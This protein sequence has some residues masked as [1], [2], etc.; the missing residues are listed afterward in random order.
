VTSVLVTNWIRAGINL[1]A[2]R[3]RAQL[4]ISACRWM[5]RRQQKKPPPQRAGAIKNLKIN[6]GGCR[7]ER[8]GVRP[9][10]Q[11]VKYLTKPKRT[12]GTRKT[13]NRV[14]AFPIDLEVFVRHN[15]AS[16]KPISAASTASSGATFPSSA[17]RQAS[18]VSILRSV[19]SGVDFL[20]STAIWGSRSEFT[21]IAPDRV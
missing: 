7:R 10:R 20:A 4:S 16:T 13:E 8:S 18:K 9:L 3:V 14:K 5:I 11:P 12:N 17:T 2:H 6:Y 21:S 19:A 1:D 15:H